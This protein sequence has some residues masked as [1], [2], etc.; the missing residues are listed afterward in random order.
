ME[1]HH[2]HVSF[3]GGKVIKYDE[4]QTMV[5]Y[6]IADTKSCSGRASPLENR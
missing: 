6:T 1:G 2:I 5:G 3:L 4:G